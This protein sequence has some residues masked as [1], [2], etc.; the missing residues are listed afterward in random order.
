MKI[1]K[2]DA[3]KLLIKLSWEILEHKWRYYEGP[4]YG[5]QPVPDAVYD[6]IESNYEKLCKA[7]NKAPTA[8]DMVGFNTERP[9][10]RLVQS[11][12][13]SD[14]KIDTNLLE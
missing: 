12:M 3:E 7:L 1:S 4:K 11:K 5:V 2:G 6:K 13:F 8:S 14:Y 10:C 9:S